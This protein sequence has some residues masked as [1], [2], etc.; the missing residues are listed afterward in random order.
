MIYAI[1][2]EFCNG[3]AGNERVNDA[4]QLNS[5]LCNL[6]HNVDSCV[7]LVATV[8]TLFTL[9]T[10]VGGV[11]LHTLAFRFGTSYRIDRLES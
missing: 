8:F 4:I 7:L 10:V 1:L 9:A 2:R 6:S 5:S 11:F 3:G